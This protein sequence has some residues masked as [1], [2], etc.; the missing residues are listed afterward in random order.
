M[1]LSRCQPFCRFWGSW[2][3]KLLVLAGKA[4]ILRAMLTQSCLQCEPRIDEPEVQFVEA[5]PICR[6]NNWRQY[7][8]K[9][10]EVI[11]WFFLPPK[12]KKNNS[13]P[14]VPGS[15]GDPKGGGGRHLRHGVP[16]H[17]GRPR[18]PEGAGLMR[19]HG[20]AL[21]RGTEN[22]THVLVFLFFLFSG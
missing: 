16:P 11:V 18:G 12:K 13:A 21:V 6:P 20:R 9:S 15:G 2:T 8:H 3:S 10:T 19:G 17:P 1:K 14:W 22:L 4:R 5:C 7:H